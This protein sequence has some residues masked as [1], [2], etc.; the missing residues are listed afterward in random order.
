MQ[1]SKLKIG[2]VGGTGYTGV[3]L[4]R[5]LAVHPNAELSV[6]TSRGEAG[7]PVADMFPSLRGYVNLNF[8]DP[9]QADLEACDVVFFATPN[10]I[11]MNQTRGLLAKGV[12]VIDLAAD[13]RIRDVA[14]WEK[15]Y[16]MSH[17]CPELLAEA[18]YGLPELNREKIRTAQ[19]VANPGCYPTAVQLG[20]MPLLEAGVVDETHLIAD[21]K[22]GVSGAGRKVETPIL[23]AEAGDNFKAYGVAGHRHLPEIS[24]GL[25]DMANKKVGLTFVPHLTP[26]IRGIHATLYATL[27]K[28]VDLQQ[29]FENRYAQERFVDVLPKG[30]HP[31]TR[32]VRGSNQCRIAVHQPQGGDTVVVLSV[33]D[34]LVKGAAG[35]AVQNMNIMFGFAENT[36]LEVVPVLP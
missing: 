32:S 10:G 16:G 30:A 28:A 34:N 24:Q 8:T 36:G 31:E 6:I 1:N 14:V 17:T 3:E 4:L 18:V 11:A 29:L 25:A 21:A 26:L 2:I 20:F 15:W 12:R 33:I 5:L 9:A 27:T 13:F 23:F 22:S 35:Q 7:L 19:L